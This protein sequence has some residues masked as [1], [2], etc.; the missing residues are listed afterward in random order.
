MGGYPRCDMCL[1]TMRSAGVRGEGGLCT[2]CLAEAL[3]IVGIERGGEFYRALKEYREG[4][5][6]GQPRYEENWFNPLPG[7]W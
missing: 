3:P 7:G 4:Q 2:R 6:I 5:D 1:R